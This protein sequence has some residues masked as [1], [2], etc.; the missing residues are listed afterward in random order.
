MVSVDLSAQVQTGCVVTKGTKLYLES[1]GL[2]VLLK[3]RLWWLGAVLQY[4]RKC[5]GFLSSLSIP[6]RSICN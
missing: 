4:P 1:V 2:S 5:K 6:I 3:V